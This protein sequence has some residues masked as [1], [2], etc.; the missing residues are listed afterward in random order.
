[1]TSQ[2]GGAVVVQIKPEIAAVTGIQKDDVI[3]AINQQPLKTAD[4]VA[5]ALP[6]RVPPRDSRFHHPASGA[7]NGRDAPVQLKLR[8]RDR[9]TLAVSR[10]PRATPRQRCS[11]SGAR[12]TASASGRSRRNS[13]SRNPEQE[14]RHPDSRHGPRRNA[15]AS[16][17]PRSRQRRR[18]R[19]TLS[20]RCD[21]PR[22]CVWRTGSHR[23][24]PHLHL[25]ATSAFVYRQRRHARHARRVDA[26]PLRCSLPCSATRLRAFAEAHA[27]LPCL[28]WAN[29]HFQPAAATTGRRCWA[30]SGCRTWHSDVEA[31]VHRLDIAAPARLR[32]HDRHPGLVS[33]GLFGGEHAKVRDLERRIA[34]KLGGHGVFAVTGQTY[35]RKAD[36]QILDVL[37]GIAQ[38]AAKTS[39]TCGCCNA[40]AN[41]WN[42]S[43]SR[44]DRLERHGVQA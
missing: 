3:F 19:Q 23:A 20:P 28:A 31:V 36:A 8:S 26:D 43:G 27:T 9:R 25:G 2:F 6:A 38:S 4:E 13:R 44:T 37:S 42:R 12:R 15:R 1:M 5:A 18:I 10:S 16:R 14:T 32:R 40:K 41:C 24:C 29:T 34:T 33:R 21:G 11:V 30:T 7:R 22:P 17:R 39:P 35:P